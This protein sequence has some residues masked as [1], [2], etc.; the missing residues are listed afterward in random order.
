MKI[1]K[2]V[3][4]YFFFVL[5]LLFL[6][7]V[8]ADVCSIPE[9]TYVG[10]VKIT[11][12][13][14]VRPLFLVASNNRISGFFAP[15]DQHSPGGAPVN[16]TDLVA[17]SEN[18]SGYNLSLSAGKILFESPSGATKGKAKRITV[19]NGSGSFKGYYTGNTGFL[20]IA[21]DGGAVLRV[22]A[23]RFFLFFFGTVDSQGDFLQKFPEKG[24]KLS[25]KVSAG[26]ASLTANV[27]GGLNTSTLTKEENG[28]CASGPGEVAESALLLQSF[29]KSIQD[30]IDTANAFV[31]EN[32]A[33]LFFEAIVDRTGRKYINRAL[34]SSP[35]KCNKLLERTLIHL[36]A[37]VGRIE[38]Q[39]CK[40]KDITVCELEDKPADFITRMKTAIKDAAGLLDVDKDSNDIADV[41]EAIDIGTN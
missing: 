34:D 40:P 23:G 11:S 13:G 7:P 30:Y 28:S 38:K 33:F 16:Q 19:K 32:P 39:L 36:F 5:M 8:Y 20:N 27:G 21:P 25:M 29:K 2:K 10:A 9:G 6:V 22:S 1:N 18:Q 14:E 41:C 3:I 26:G 4:F 12:T 35:I 15:E 31:K 24:P 37:D 17:N